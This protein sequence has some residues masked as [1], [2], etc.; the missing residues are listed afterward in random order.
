M[1]HI[2]YT[3]KKDEPRKEKKEE[4]TLEDG[5]RRVPLKVTL[6]EF[7][8]KVFVLFGLGSKLNFENRIYINEFSSNAIH[9]N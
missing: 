6:R 9:S 5:F 1:R 4:L 2:R 7:L 8:G 3:N